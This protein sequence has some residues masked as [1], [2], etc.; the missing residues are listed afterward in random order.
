MRNVRGRAEG[1]REKGRKRGGREKPK[2][3]GKIPSTWHRQLSF[4]YSTTP[5]SNLTSLSAAIRTVNAQQVL[6]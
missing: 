3:G 6:L 2:E 4:R 1:G 5:K